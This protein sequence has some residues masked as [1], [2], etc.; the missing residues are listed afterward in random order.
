[1]FA[2]TDFGVAPSAQY[3]VVSAGLRIRYSGTELNKGGTIRALQ[4]PNHDSIIGL[5]AAQIEGYVQSKRFPVTRE[6]S[7]VVY[8]PLTD[9]YNTQTGSGGFVAPYAVPFQGF[10]VSSTSGNEFE[11]EYVVN[12][13]VSGRNVRGQT[14]CFKDPVGYAAITSAMAVE[15]GSFHG[16]PA[17]M[18]KTIF[19]LVKEYLTKAAT[20]VGEAALEAVPIVVEHAPSILSA[21]AAMI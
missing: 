12:Y 20:W 17:K 1:M 4:H 21:V 2:S 8:C 16:A 15:G 9:S 3:R 18:E 13:E 19:G 11:F 10:L 14:V 5:T 6:W 7:H